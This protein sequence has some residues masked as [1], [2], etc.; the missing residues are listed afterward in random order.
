MSASTTRRARHFADTDTAAAAVRVSARASDTSPVVQATQALLRRFRG[1]RPLRGGSLL[2]TI[3]GDSIAP[4]GGV[5]T[6]GSLI[7][8]A[9]PFGLAERLVRTSVA[10][11]AQDGWLIARRDGRRSEYRLTPNGQHR[12]AEATK[13]IYGKSPASWDGQWTLIVLPPAGGKRRESLREEFR[14]LGFGQ[15]S[16]GVFAHPSCSLAQARDWVRNLD[17]SKDA[18]LLQSSSEELAVDRRLVAAGWDLAGLARRYQRF[19]KAFRPIQAA[20][21]PGVS[22]PA[23][24]AP[25]GAGPLTAEA[26]FVIRTLLIHDYRKIHLQ[27]PLLPP[28]LLP[29]DW[30][31]STA[32][33]LCSRL[34]GTVFAA[35]EYFLSQTA[36]TLSEPLPRVNPEAC[37]RFG[38][39]STSRC[40]GASAA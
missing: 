14:W 36:S 3:F 17:A 4:R 26:A 6:L 15:V 1:R 11:L 31:G 37:A 10:R 8:L 12:F 23:A 40:S 25:S 22:V 29:D 16:A 27:D 30:I 21:A 20:V 13:R 38:G 39:I 33:D 18:L 2:V 34:Y 35:A 5:V 7:R 32:Y 28:A 24:P 9:Q 19:V